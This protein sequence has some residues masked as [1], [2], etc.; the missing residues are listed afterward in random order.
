M[1]GKA[2]LLRSVAAAA[3]VAALGLTAAGANAGIVGPCSASI[4][5]E[6]VRL[7]GT[8]ARDQAIVV[9]KDASVPIVMTAAGTI[10]HVR[11][12]LAFAGFSWTVKDTAVGSSVYRGTIPVKDYARYGVGLYKVSGVA[13]GPGVSCTGTALVRVK[14]SPLTTIAG[15]V[16]LGAAALGGLG[17]LGSMLGGGGGAGI[18]PFRI[19]RGSIAGLIAGAGGLVLLQQFAVLYPTGLVAAIG[20]ALGVGAGGAAPWLGRLLHLGRA[21][22]TSGRFTPPKALAH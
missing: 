13:S 10:S 19:G 2:C 5:G 21:T 6:G 11:V 20:L 4:A 8:G 18:S 16:G 14:G 7:A 15:G 1:K 9:A 3:G 12:T 22:G 17:V